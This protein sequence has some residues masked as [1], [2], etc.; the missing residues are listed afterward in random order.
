MANVKRIEAEGFN[1]AQHSLLSHNL[2]LSIV[3][4]VRVMRG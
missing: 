2:M 3:R 1:L 4:I